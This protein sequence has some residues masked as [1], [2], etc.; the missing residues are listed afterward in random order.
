MESTTVISWMKQ[1]VDTY[2]KPNLA[3]KTFESYDI[4]ERMMED[5]YPE[6]EEMPLRQM[7][8]LYAQQILNG[9]A[10]QYSKSTLNSLRVILH[11]SMQAASENSALDVQPL[12]KLRIPENA[13]VK[14][15]RALTRTE[16][17][18]VEEAAQRILLGH[19]TLFFL[20]TGL[21]SEELCNLNWQDYNPKTR[22]IFI[23][24]SKS[25]AGV[26]H[27]PLNKEAQR[28]LLSQ[29]RLKTDNAIFH[30]SRGGRVTKSVLTKLYKRL[31][32]ATGI[33][34]ITTHVYR[35]TFATRALE[36]GMNV[37][38]LS[39]ILGHKDVAFTMQRYCSPDVKFLREQVDL[40]DHIRESRNNE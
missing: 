4:V 40:L 11:E 10:D 21:R 19:I 30:S 33:E 17:A 24:E 23:R 32:R 39:Q 8:S 7:N 37:K 5:H 29:R 14:E 28:I 27:V 12:G 34:C 15:V 9:L 26:R 16:Q 38:A 22:M 13:A 31:R 36:D 25:S 20:N 2:V 35:H 6:L 18:E 3:E 1:W